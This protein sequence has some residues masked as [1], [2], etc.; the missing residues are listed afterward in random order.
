MRWNAENPFRDMPYDLNE[1]RSDKGE[2]FWWELDAMA[3]RIASTIVQ[4]LAVGPAYQLLAEI[5]PAEKV[6]IYFNNRIKREISPPLLALF[7]AQWCSEYGTTGRPNEVVWRSHE[8]LGPALLAHW[9]NDDIP[10]ILGA[11]NKNL[12]RTGRS[13]ARW[14]YR[15]SRRLPRQLRQA[16]S[17]V[18]T[19]VLPRSPGPTIAVHYVE[20]IDPSRRSDLFW[21]ED[22]LVDPLRVLIFFDRQRAADRGRRIPESVLQAIEGWG[23]RWVGLEHDL[24]E[25]N[26]APVWLHETGGTCLLTEF[27]GRKSSPVGVNER[28]TNQASEWFLAEV[29]YWMSFYKAFDVKVHADIAGAKDYHLAQSV[30][31]DL[32]D[33]VRV[34]WQRSEPSTPEATEVG[35]HSNQVYFPWS[36]RVL[37]GAT[38]TRSRIGPAV[39]TGFPF[40]VAWES[41][42]VPN[43]LKAKL[44]D[45]GAQFVVALFDDSFLQAAILTK[46][47][48][49]AWYKGFLEWVLED[50][51]VGV[52][53]KSK[54]PEIIEEL[55]EI[56]GLMARAEKTGRWINLT[57]VFGRLPSDASRA[58]DISIGVSISTAANEAVAAG[59]RAI[60]YDNTG[61]TYHLFYEWGYEK[62]V[63]TDL[64]RMM[65]ALK[66]YKSDPA[67]EPGLGDFSYFI[68]QVDPFRDGRAGKRIGSYLS[69]LLAGFD[70]GLDRNQVIE[71]AN[72]SYSS[73]WGSNSV[74]QS[75]EPVPEAQR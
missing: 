72:H 20:G 69:Y 54:K 24:V 42:T 6:L 59:G 55:P 13:L 34:G 53:T 63:F 44:A 65:A 25:R 52:L 21:Y 5:L 2:S 39:V 70:A 3:V 30:A 49:Q 12:Y 51:Q 48:V 47:L 71:R 37:A 4:D 14:V 15:R 9:P 35:H 41:E 60:H 61:R 19:P 40:D 16:L 8:G 75:R 1:M 22:G 50:P 74:I 67:N 57:D 10:L 36:A 32:L 27:Q 31:F 33:G 11:P 43:E 23:M 38:E 45:N 26:V 68:D 7:V 62:V 46:A 17:R 56:H 28:W 66:R 64:D 73:I 18:S 29:D 58:A